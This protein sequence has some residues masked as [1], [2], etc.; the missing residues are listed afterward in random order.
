MSRL[1]ATSGLF[2]ELQRRI[3]DGM[4][5]F[6]TCAGMILLATEV[7]DGRPDQR[8]FGAIDISAPSA[9]KWASSRI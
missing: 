9:S 7:L 4:P 8:S 1:L 2:D 5:V 3:D 6:G